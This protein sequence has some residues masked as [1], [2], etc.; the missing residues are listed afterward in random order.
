M[1]GNSIMGKYKKCKKCGDIQLSERF[2]G[3]ICNKCKNPTNAIEK[4]KAKRFG[5]FD[6]VKKALK[7]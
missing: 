3:D 5:L 7:I 2:D 1:E 6:Y 4:H